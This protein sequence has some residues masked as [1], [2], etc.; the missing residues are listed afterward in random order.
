MDGEAARSL[1]GD[2]AAA[3]RQGFGDQGATAGLHGLQLMTR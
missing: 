2:D 1:L 3:S